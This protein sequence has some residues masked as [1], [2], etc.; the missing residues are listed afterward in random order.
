MKQDNICVILWLCQGI[1]RGHRVHFS[2]PLADTVPISESITPTRKTSTGVTGEG[3]TMQ[4]K[5]SV[6]L[7]LLQAFEKLASEVHAFF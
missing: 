5:D 4:G 7:P 2:T 3:L 6:A 1:S